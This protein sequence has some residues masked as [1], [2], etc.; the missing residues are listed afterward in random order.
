MNTGTVYAIRDLPLHERPRERL[1]SSGP[2]AL[3]EAELLAIILRTGTSNENV[4]ELSKRILRDY[5]LAEL[6]LLG[7]NEVQK[8]RGIS[9]VKACQILS[10]AEL[11]RRINSFSRAPLTQINSSKDVFNLLSP[12]LRF[13]R[14]ESFIGLYLDTRNALIKKET[15]SLGSLNTSVVHPREIF[16]SAIRESANSVIIVHNHPSGN[17][18]PSKED[19]D[20]TRIL[21]RAG[22]LIGIPII[23]H[24]IIGDSSYFSL[25]DRQSL[26]F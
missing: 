10:C 26:K 19:I 5:T 7:F 4:V 8:F 20:I 13:L 1:I 12:E 9:T 23:D 25:A 15:I 24:V 6:S 16:S 11:A 2:G 3:S 18:E 21:V 22:Q 14:K 17:P